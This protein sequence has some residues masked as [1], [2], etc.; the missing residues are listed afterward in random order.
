MYIQTGYGSFLDCILW[1][2]HSFF[3]SVVVVIYIEM[4]AFLSFVFICTSRTHPTES[5]FTTSSTVEKEDVCPG[6]PRVNS[7]VLET[8]RI[9][10]TTILHI[11]CRVYT[12]DHVVTM[13]IE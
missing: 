6:Q 10:E 13:Q 11:L 5:F 1:Y 7:I 12:T 8:I 4:K 2:V 3:F 9:N